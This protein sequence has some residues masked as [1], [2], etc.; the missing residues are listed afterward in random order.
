MTEPVPYSRQLVD[1]ADID[2]VVSVLRS[3]FLTQGPMVPL[4]EEAI[5]S[6][7]GATYA[8]AVNSATSALHISLMAMGIGE[9]DL[10]WTAA[11]SFAASAN[12]ALYV[13]AQV[14][15]VDID[16]VS[17][18]ISPSSLET[19]LADAQIKPKVLIVV[20]FGGLSCD[21]EGLARIC[22][23]HS[24]R[25][26]EDSSHAIGASYKGHP[27]GK[28]QFSDVSIFSL[29]PVKII[30]SGE[31]GVATTNDLGLAKRI[32]SL[33]TH[34]IVRDDLSAQ[35]KATEPWIYEQRD[36]GYNYRLTDI[37]AALGMSQTE[38]LEGFVQQ[39]NEVAANYKAELAGSDIG[40][41]EWGYEA[42][43]SYHLFV[44]KLPSS[45]VRLEKYTQLRQAGFL[46]NV[47][48]VPIYHH[49]YYRENGFGNFFLPQ[50]EEYYSVALSLPCYVNMPDW[51]IPKVCQIL[52]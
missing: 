32:R 26:I 49:P 39:R 5:C 11:N 37:A 25:I 9:G 34:G 19:K 45:K 16:P 44:V 48:Y 20:N 17:L 1:E 42:R 23:E 7:T 33:R 2:S 27:V 29:H 30:T 24:I 28:A 38:K 36:L 51:V 8:V 35:Q 22:A 50:T 40:W 52:K 12:C 43:S 31:G 15:F 46:V 4:F 21:M 10:V 13:G 18:V 6:Q 41:Q 3:E 14:D 47:H